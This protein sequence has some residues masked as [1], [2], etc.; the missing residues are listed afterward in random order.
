MEG[1]SQPLLPGDI[2]AA[3]DWWRTAG[4]DLDFADEPV[5]WLAQEEASEQVA[6]L[7]AAYAA[8][9]EK[10]AAAAAQAAAS[11][12]AGPI[13]GA[14][15]SWPA[16]L[17]ALRQWWMEEPSLDDGQVRGRVPPRGEAGAELMVV[18]SHPEPDDREVLL[19]GPA[20][21]FLEA[22][23]AAC[24]IGPD[25]IY[26]ASVLPR[27]TPAADWTALQSNGIGAILAHH[28]KLVRPQRLILFGAHIPPLL[29]HDPAQIAKTSLTFNHE[30]GTI[31]MMGAKDLRA[32]AGKPAQK[33]AF[34][35][36]WL[37]FS[38]S[39]TDGLH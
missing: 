28:V 34:W 16:D 15:A 24:G 30:H 17:A 4:V 21:A 18:L 2:T 5:S 3:L 12:S 29:G 20:G 13:G 39:S 8:A 37:A 22:I 23:T 10:R 35:Q 14:P 36:R 11:A 25:A 31:P 38:G 33:A 19:E 27:H 1:T 7:P 26:L 9:P 32:Y 6:P